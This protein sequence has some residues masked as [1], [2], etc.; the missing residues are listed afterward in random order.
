M[1]RLPVDRPLLISIIV[2]VIAGLFIF[3]SA[4][5]GLLARDG[6]IYSSVTLSRALFGL[7][8]GTILAFFTSRVPYK[9]W[10]KWSPLIF[11]FSLIATALVFVPGLGV[12]FGGAKRWIDLGPLTF[13]TSELLKIGFII[14]LA[15]WISSV[16]EKTATW[17]HGLL[18]FLVMAGLSGILLLSQPDLDTFL[19][20]FATGL[21]ILLVGG[22]SW[23]QIGTLVLIAVI[24]FVLV[25]YF[26]PYVRERVYTFLN[27]TRDSLGAGYQIQQS[28]IAI[29]S[30]QIFGRG[31]GQSVQKF[32]FLPEPIGDSI[33]AV[34]A[35]EFGFVGS[36]LLILLYLF[37]AF[38]GLKIAVRAP[39]AFG[40]L[41][42]LGIVIMILSQSFLNMGAM[43]GILPLLGVPL[44]FVSHGGSALLVTF[45][46]VGILLNISR[47]MRQKTE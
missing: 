17:R 32:N 24:G 7:I 6:S 10:R 8:L 14:Y 15:A 41:L 26:R 18:P 43:L 20:I 4:A 28:F 42:A 11:L 2:L 23:K 5:L 40:G 34:S 29:G 38:R 3:S 22:G 33:F 13:Q 30:G 9:N 36:V 35:E 16:K 12:E 47:S 44:L 46:E 21:A 45:A 37:F 27:P 1:K 39:D 31:F 19:I 25:A